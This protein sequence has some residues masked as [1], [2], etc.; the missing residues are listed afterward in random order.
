MAA[1]PSAATTGQFLQ[2]VA[3]LP[4]PDLTLP[5]LEP[6]KSREQYRERPEAETEEVKLAF[7]VWKT[8]LPLAADSVDCKLQTVSVCISGRGR[9][10][11]AGAHTTS[12]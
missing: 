11:K 10:M 12:I 7:L 9:L 6:A 8:P 4:N 3:G 5:A 2:A 1:M